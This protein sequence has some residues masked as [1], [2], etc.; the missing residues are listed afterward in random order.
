MIIRWVPFDVTLQNENP[1]NEHHEENGMNG[2][3]YELESTKEKTKDKLSHH[4]ETTYN[5]YCEYSYSSL[6]YLVELE[7]KYSRRW[8]FGKEV[9]LRQ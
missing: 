9:R 4:H 8:S 5:H 6:S 2:V 7:L 3:R 1:A